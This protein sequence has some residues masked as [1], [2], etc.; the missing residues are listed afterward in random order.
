MQSGDDASGGW[1]DVPAGP[2]LG[3]CLAQV[4]FAALEDDQ[5]L[6]LLTAEARQLAY[7]QARVWAVLAEIAQRDPM[8]QAVR[9]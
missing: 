7:Q 1:A 2:Q 4:E 5:L 9:G 3:A 8:P 6:E